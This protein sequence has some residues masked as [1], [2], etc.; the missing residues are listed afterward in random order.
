M[1]EQLSDR[2]LF[3]EA[4][5]IALDKGL[6]K[7]AYNWY[8]MAD[9]KLGTRW[10]LKKAQEDRDLQKF[11]AANATSLFNNYKKME[12]NSLGKFCAN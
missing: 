1:T 11:L 8:E 5:D 9:Y 3:R 6:Y 12:V 7:E 4:G 2:Q 10:V